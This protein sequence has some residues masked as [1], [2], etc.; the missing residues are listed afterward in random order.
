M[1][2]HAFIRVWLDRK[3]WLACVLCSHRIFESEPTYPIQEV[4]K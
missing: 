1:C 3:W 2:E 4:Q